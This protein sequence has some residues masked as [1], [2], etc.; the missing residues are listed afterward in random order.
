MSV[1]N[2]ALRIVPAL[3]TGERDPPGAVAVGGFAVLG[4]L[5]AV[6]GS[7]GVLS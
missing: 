7:I 4:L 6:N 2:E 1:L 5:L 3:G